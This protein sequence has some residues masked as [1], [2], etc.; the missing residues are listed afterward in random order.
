[1]TEE[2]LNVR[3]LKTYFYT[4]QGVVKAVDGVTF[5]VRKGETFGLVGESGCGKSVT[6][7]SIM[8]LI[9][10]PPG[11][12][13][14]GEVLLEGED[15][16]RKT[17]EETRKMRGR[18]M[19]M[20]FQDPTSSLN[21]IMKI[22]D[23]ILETI[24]EHQ[25]LDKRD[26]KEKA[27]AIMQSVGIPNPSLR[28]EEYPFQFS[29]GMRQ[30]AMI[31]IA[32]SCNPSLLIADEPTTN[33][34]VTVQAQTLELIKSI[35]E[36][37]GIAVL[38]IT[39]NL[40]LVAW[41]CDRVAVMYSGRIVEQADTGAIFDKARH[42]YTRALLEC[43]PRISERDDKRLRVIKGRVP[44]LISVPPGCSFH[45]RCPYSIDMC[46]DREPELVE[47]EKDHWVS[48]FLSDQLAGG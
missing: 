36:K 46:S 2:L 26:A 7:L 13:V 15:V 3:G 38:L 8:R 37:E 32:T 1:M 16:L 20:I 48:C 24:L 5:S 43:I 25:D 29:G 35:S 4:R 45:P 14:G 28:Y 44:N 47:V 18:K 6:A 22:G 33:L 39:H 23:Q 40:G 11:K 41:L 9:S 42:P 34:D 27:I 31:A 10:D 19:S 30:R 12:T 17:T 21:P